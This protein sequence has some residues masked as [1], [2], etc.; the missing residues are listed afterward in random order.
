MNNMNNKKMTQIIKT[1]EKII[2]FY[3]ESNLRRKTPNS[4][5]LEITINVIE[6]KYETNKEYFDISFNYK[7][8]NDENLSNN[9]KLEFYNNV[10]PFSNKNIKNSGGEIVIKNSCTSVMIEYILMDDKELEKY[11][12]HTTHQQYRADLMRAI[13]S[14]W[15]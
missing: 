2:K 14:L 7:Y 6:K 13:V 10:H 5:Y 3:D 4:P 1:S 8:F 9:E 15:D 12:G 11:T